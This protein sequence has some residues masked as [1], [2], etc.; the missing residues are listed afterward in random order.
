MVSVR[1]AHTVGSII[2]A[3]GADQV[4]LEITYG[5]HLAKNVIPSRIT[6]G[7]M[8]EALASNND[9]EGAYD[10]IQQALAEPQTK[11][12]VNAVTYSSVLKSFNHQKSFHRV[13][14]VYDEM[15]RGKVEF[16]VTTYNALLDVC[17]RSGEISR[18]EPL[19]KEM[20]VQGITPNI[21]TYG[22]VIKA[23]CS[24]N[25]LDQAFAV[26]SDMQA[27]TDLHPDEVTYNTL[28]DGCARYGSF[29]RGL[30]VM[31]DM[32]KAKVPPSNY[33]LSVIAK[34]ANRSKKPKLA[35]QMVE[36]LRR[37][38]R[39]LFALGIASRNVFT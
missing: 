4:R 26:F 38:T 29:D 14:D 24:A 25:R 33:T 18:A 8:V 10:I 22:T 39:E 15:I 1:S 32:K 20:A 30:E 35:F 12:L 28:L 19:L 3:Y 16:S 23:Y 21:I 9:P 13:W 31:A 34:L 36:E 5:K 27:N 17:A 7:C 6:L 11:G 2:R 37:G